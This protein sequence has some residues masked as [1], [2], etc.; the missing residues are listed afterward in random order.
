M[1]EYL[2]LKDEGRMVLLPDD[3][4]ECNPLQCVDEKSKASRKYNTLMD[5]HVVERMW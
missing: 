1:S 3:S 2:L 5:I 4:P